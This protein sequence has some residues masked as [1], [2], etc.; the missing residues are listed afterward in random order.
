[1]P[2]LVLAF[3]AAR[4]DGFELGAA[5]RRFLKV[6]PQKPDGAGVRGGQYFSLNVALN[7]ALV[8]SKAL[9]IHLLVKP[10]GQLDPFPQPGVPLLTLN[11]SARGQDT[12]LEQRSR[13]PLPALTVHPC[14]VWP[15]SVLSPENWMGFVYTVEGL[16]VPGDPSSSHPLSC[17]L[18][19]QS[20]TDFSCGPC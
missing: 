1:M 19:S 3:P 5:L 9:S 2:R 10:P 20:Y 12:E 4:R 7:L 14:P 17:L 6:A 13:P 8:P 18:Y 16:P 11:T 15:P